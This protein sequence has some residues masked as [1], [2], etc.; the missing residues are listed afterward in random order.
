MDLSELHLACYRRVS[1]EIESVLRQKVEDLHNHLHSS[2]LQ[3]KQASIASVLE[4]LLK[5]SEDD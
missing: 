1:K 5:T 2:K 3:E 4:I